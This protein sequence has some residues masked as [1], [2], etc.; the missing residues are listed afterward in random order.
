MA[1]SEMNQIQIDDMSSLVNDP[2]NKKMYRAVN[3][4][5]VSNTNKTQTIGMM[6][7]PDNS[8]KTNTKLMMQAVAYFCIHDVVREVY[9][10]GEKTYSDTVIVNCENMY[11]ER[12][13]IK[14][15]YA[16]FSKKLIKSAF[17]EQARHA[18]FSADI[19]ETLMN[20]LLFNYI[21][22]TLKE[23][24]VEIPEKAGFYS[25]NSGYQYISHTDGTYE[26]E[27]VRQAKYM[28]YSTDSIDYQVL[29]SRLENDS[30][31]MVLTVL[32]IASFMYT[33]LRDN[34]HDFR[35]II[36]VT[37]CDTREKL[38]MFR[39]FFNVFDR[40]DDDTLSLNLKLNELRN[41]LFSRKD[42]TVI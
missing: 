3:K 1:Q 29:K 20:H 39:D 15:D 17:E 12:F 6:Q 24:I 35:K 11:S 34:G 2:Q 36:A 27:T 22:S 41:I 16:R 42:E 18:V 7:L 32:D 26:T 25:N 30:L 4:N 8:I 13:T 23:Q 28:D 14:I 19:K 37:G 9:K 21:R 31:L 38:S 10:A 33:I 40:D 5:R